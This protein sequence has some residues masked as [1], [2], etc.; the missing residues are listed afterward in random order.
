MPGSQAAEET[1]RQGNARIIGLL[2]TEWEPSGHELF[3]LIHVK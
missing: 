1:S 3:E 2:R